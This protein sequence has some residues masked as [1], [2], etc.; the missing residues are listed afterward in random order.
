MKCKPQGCVSEISPF[1]LFITQKANLQV[2][3]RLRQ[4]NDQYTYTAVRRVRHLM[5]DAAGYCSRD[6]A[7]CPSSKT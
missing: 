6:S 2:V 1:I 7:F 4:Q 5:V 3:E